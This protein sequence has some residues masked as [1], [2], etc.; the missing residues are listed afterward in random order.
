MEGLLKSDGFDTILVVADRLSK[1]AHFL[2]LKH[3]YSM[4]SVANIFVR[5]VVHLYGGVV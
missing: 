5:E 4:I 1:Y 2:P 3:F